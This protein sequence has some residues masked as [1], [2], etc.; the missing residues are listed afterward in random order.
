MNYETNS[1]VLCLNFS[2]HLEMQGHNSFPDPQVLPIAHRTDRTSLLVY[3]VCR[4][5]VVTVT[6]GS[7][8]HV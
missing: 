5:V 3:G 8:C 1:V 4:L 2:P 7:V 6:L